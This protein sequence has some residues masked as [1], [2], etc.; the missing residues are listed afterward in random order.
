M[1]DQDHVDAP[2]TP[3]GTDDHVPGLLDPQGIEDAF[4]Q[5]NALRR[6]MVIASAALTAEREEIEEQMNN[7]NARISDAIGPYAEEIERLKHDIEKAVM[8]RQSSEKTD[9]GKA[10]YYKARKP[11]IKWD[12]KALQG[13]AIDHP[14]IMKF[15]TEGKPGKPRVKI[16][17]PEMPSRETIIS[18]AEAAG[19][20]Q[21]STPGGAE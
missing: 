5:I 3:A 15:R 1:S 16:D 12:D 4:Y 7:V 11:S 17:L 8:Y 10:T 21:Y 9:A 2:L 19:G 14:E 6:E 13:Y 20:L 18:D